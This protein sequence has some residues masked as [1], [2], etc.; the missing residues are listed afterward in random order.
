MAV[1]NAIFAAQKNKVAIDSCVLGD[2]ST[3]LQQASEITGGTYVKVADHAKLTQVLLS[4]FL[5]SVEFRKSFNIPPAARV[6][7]LLKRNLCYC[8][9]DNLLFYLSHSRSL[10]FKQRT[11]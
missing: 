11:R 9:C 2:D 8:L 10:L 6:R 4:I 3:F 7:L 5:M 1:M